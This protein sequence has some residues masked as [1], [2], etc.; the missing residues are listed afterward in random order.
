MVTNVLSSE[1]QIDKVGREGQGVGFD[2]EGNIYFVPGTVPGD[3][4]RV[5]Y[6]DRSPRYRD[7]EAVEWLLRSPDREPSRCRFSEKCGGCDWI[8]W[9]YSAQ[10]QAKEQML[11]HLLDKLGMSPF[12]FAPTLAASKLE[13][14]RNRIQLRQKGSQLGFFRRRSHEIVDIDRCAVAH[15]ALNEELGRLR[16]EHSSELKKIELV[17]HES[18]AVQRFINE[19]HGAGG[20]V[21]VNPEQNQRLRDVVGEALRRVNAEKVLELYC[22]NGN[23][24]SVYATDVKQV[25][26]VDNHRGAVDLACALRLGTQI[27]FVCRPVG[28]GLLPHLPA[29]FAKG[30]DTVLLDP[31]RS[32]SMGMLKHFLKPHVQTVVYV[33]CSLSGFSFDASDLKRQFQIARVQLIDMFPHTRHLEFV[34]TL[35]RK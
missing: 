29:D 27:S 7:A 35:R 14:Y 18:G 33:S 10:L 31:P 6:S 25:V 12:E 30:F 34:V 2:P 5:V 24:T 4:V 26:A 11:Q 28:P 23:L 8:H 1:I 32:G 13:G 20:F 9:K 22:G 17:L 15:P 21:Q 3:R 19:P 16:S